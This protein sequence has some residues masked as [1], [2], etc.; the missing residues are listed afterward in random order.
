MAKAEYG[1]LP[2]L[3]LLFSPEFI[4]AATAAASSSITGRRPPIPT[5]TDVSFI[6]S[7]CLATRYPALCIR[8]LSGYAAVIRRSDH[9]LAQ[10]ALLISLSRARSA[11]SFVTRLSRARG[12]GQWDHG[13]VID[14]VE[15]MGDTVDRLAQSIHEIAR[16]GRSAGGNFEWH[17]SN[18]Q[19]WVSAA[20]TDETTC[21]DGFTRRS[22]ADPI[23]KVAVRR[24]VV[25]VA[26]VTSNA[27]ALVNRFASRHQSAAGMP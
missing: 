22:P 3:L 2:I 9:H 12:L 10:V 16:A 15:N 13:A 7:S 6:K 27:L 26:Q 14:C 25:N 8:Y 18:V 23:V 1:L 21:M 4:P 11:A 20:L 5:L 17:M 19:T 24:R